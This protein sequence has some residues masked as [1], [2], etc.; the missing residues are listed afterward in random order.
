MKDCTA[1]PGYL[2]QHLFE[3]WVSTHVTKVPDRQFGFRIHLHAHVSIT[4][5]FYQCVFISLH[6]HIC[7]H[8]HFSPLVG[9]FI[10]QKS[11]LLWIICCS[12]SRRILRTSDTDLMS[13]SAE[14]LV[15]A[16]G[17]LGNDPGR[18]SPCN[19]KQLDK[20]KAI[21]LSQ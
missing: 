4:S 21:R 2:R 15:N 3:V 20:V 9:F 13:L 16:L 12:L 11:Q 14:E 19:G 8:N 17:A 1:W 18:S 5:R 7:I 10:L 6:L